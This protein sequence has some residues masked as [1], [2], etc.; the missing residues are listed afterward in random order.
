MQ[1][2]YLTSIERLVRDQW[3]QSGIYASVDWVAGGNFEGGLYRKYLRFLAD[4][5]IVEYRIDKLCERG[6][7]ART[8]EIFTGKYGSSYKGSISIV[9]KDYRLNGFVLGDN[10]EY[11]A[12]EIEYFGE[13]RRATEGYELVPDQ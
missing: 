3:Y 6:G 7:Q 2:K 8:G 13:R 10:N 1:K 5:S 9:L 4:S 12:C 11:I